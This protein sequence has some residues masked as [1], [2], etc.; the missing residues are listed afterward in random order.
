[1]TT[2]LPEGLGQRLLALAAAPQ[3]L[4]CTDYDGTLAPLAPRPEQARLLPGASDL[5]YRLAALADTRVA[6]VSGRARGNLRSH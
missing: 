6:I 5:L 3:L 4:L 2:P 1:M